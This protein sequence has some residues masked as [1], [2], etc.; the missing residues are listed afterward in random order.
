MVKK[1]AAVCLMMA[2]GSTVQAEDVSGSRTFIG[3][4][5]DNTKTDRSF[6]LQNGPKVNTSTSNVVEYGARFGA[7]NDEWRTTLLYTYY[8]DKTDLSEETMNKGSFLMDYFFLTTGTGEVEFKPYIGLHVGYM[9]YELTDKL[10]RPGENTTVSNGNGI[11]YGGQV[12]VE[13]LFSEL[14]SLDLAY[15]YSL[16]GVTD[17]QLTSLN[18]EFSLDNMGSITFSINYFF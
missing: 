13:V 15:K 1:I 14:V 6:T 9:T 5:M 7:E 10:F 18:S 12:G 4:E 8:N 16:T 11:F 2:L 17:N 3:F